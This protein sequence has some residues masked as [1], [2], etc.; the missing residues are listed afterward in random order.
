MSSSSSFVLTGRITSAS[1]QSFSSQGCWAKMNSM[2]GWR[3]ART[4]L[5]P[6]FQQVMKQ[7]ES[8]QT[9]WILEQPSAG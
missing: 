4:K 8:V 1:R 3:M 9:M 6:S 7:G 5:L 2:S